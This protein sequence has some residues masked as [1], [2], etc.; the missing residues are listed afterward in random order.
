MR[1]L[2]LTLPEII[3]AGYSLSG[4]ELPLGHI[5]L[6]KADDKTAP[7]GLNNT[8]RQRNRL[9]DDDCTL[10]PEGGRMWR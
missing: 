7:K 2:D 5:I 9:D 4:G 10:G 8:S 3:G 1:L 6:C